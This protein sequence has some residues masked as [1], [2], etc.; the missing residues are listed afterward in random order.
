MGET[1]FIS[2]FLVQ[3]QQQ[4][5]AYQDI[6]QSQQQTK[7]D[8]PFNKITVSDAI[9]LITIRLGRVEQWS[10]TKSGDPSSNPVIAN[11]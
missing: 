2:S 1:D 4:N 7:K 3:Q 11:F 8:K 5:K 10:L 6:P 9:G